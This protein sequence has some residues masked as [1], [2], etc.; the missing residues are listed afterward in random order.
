MK[1]TYSNLLL[2]ILKHQKAFFSQNI[3]N[4]LLGNHQFLSNTNSIIDIGI[5]KIIFMRISTSRCRTAL[6]IIF[7]Y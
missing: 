5:A 6:Y 1:D 4:K 3:C 7:I 2:L